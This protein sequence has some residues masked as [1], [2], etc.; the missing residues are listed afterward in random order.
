MPTGKGKLNPSN[1]LFVW[2][3]GWFLINTCM[4]VPCI[5]SRSPDVLLEVRVIMRANEDLPPC[6]SSAVGRLEGL[7]F[8]L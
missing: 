6:Q 1:F 2:L 5:T 4:Y 3:V 8:T 7:L